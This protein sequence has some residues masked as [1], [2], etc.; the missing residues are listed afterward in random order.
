MSVICVVGGSVG[1]PVGRIPGRSVVGVDRRCA[2]V[3]PGSARTVAAVV[4][5]NDEVV[6]AVT[7]VGSGMVVGGVEVV[8]ATAVVVETACGVASEP[9]DRS[10]ATA[11]PVPAS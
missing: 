8:S 9:P 11:T 1:G 5:G 2:A 10:R 4:A 3:V 6:G 7:V